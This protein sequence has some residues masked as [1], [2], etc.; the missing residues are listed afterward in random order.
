MTNSMVVHGVLTEALIEREVVAKTKSGE[1]VPEAWVNARGPNNMFW[2]KEHDK[3]IVQALDM[4]GI[5]VPNF[6]GGVTA[7]SECVCIE[8][9]NGDDQKWGYY[10][11]QAMWMTEVWDFVMNEVDEIREGAYDHASK[12]KDVVE[13]VMRATALRLYWKMKAALDETGGY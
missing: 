6:D 9:G 7:C 5:V 4:F 1:E 11:Y 2:S 3:W 10:G 13:K 12:K 8:Y